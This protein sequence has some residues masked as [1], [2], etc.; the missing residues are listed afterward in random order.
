MRTIMVGCD[1]AL[2]GGLRNWG[3]KEACIL[4]EQSVSAAKHDSWR[5]I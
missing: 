2:S 3:T 5:T 4:T 1:Y